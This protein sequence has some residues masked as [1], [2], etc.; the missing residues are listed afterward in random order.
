MNAMLKTQYRA[1]ARS[2]PEPVVIA[3]QS[4][5]A[6]NRCGQKPKPSGRPYLRSKIQATT[7]SAAPT[8]FETVW[9]NSQSELQSGVCRCTMS[10]ARSIEKN[11]IATDAINR[12][13]G[14][15]YLET[16]STE[17]AM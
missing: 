13:K 7:I 2:P 17:A 6:P 3:P 16:A 9:R 4:V 11:Q 15:G 8:I 14:N 1:A 5:N 12:M 10:A